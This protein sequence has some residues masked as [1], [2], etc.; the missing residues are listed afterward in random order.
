MEKYDGLKL[1][2]LFYSE[3]SSSSMVYEIFYN[4]KKI[5]K[6]FLKNL[7][8]LTIDKDITVIKEKNYPR[9]G[10]V[11]IFLSF[12]SKGKKVNI[13][14]EVK[15]HDYLS[16]RP[17]QIRTYYEAAKEELSDDNV[18]FIYL[19]QFNKNNF[20]SELKVAL[21]NSIKE[22]EDS[23]NIIP[24]GKIKHINWEEFH[25]F[26][27]S[28]KDSL[29]KEYVLILNLHKNWITTK[30][31]EDI[32]LNIIDVGERD[33]SNYFSDIDI[34]I[35]KELTFGKIYNKDKKK[36][37][38]VNLEQ[39]NTGQLNKISSVIKKL[40]SSNSINKRVKQITKEET[41]KGV[42]EFLSS[43]TENSENWLLLS[44]YSSLFDYVSR[45]DY[46]KLHGT[47]SRGFSIKVNIKN[48]GSISLCTLWISKKIDFSVKR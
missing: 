35:E 3:I 30:S 36:I 33:L 47:G 17:D 41:L 24:E 40:A 22:F 23:T 20:S 4:H 7:F 2:S 6:E 48:K 12:N 16:V 26:I 39:C 32:E 28:Y 19:T 8:G 10:S 38:S 21:P 9:Q 44:F 31:K 11:D 1:N 34:D 14:I 5:V 42:K 15:V 37:L 29:P 43:L 13:L 18:Y 46:L 27:G 45:I 25:R